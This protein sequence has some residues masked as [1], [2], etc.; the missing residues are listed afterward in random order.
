MTFAQAAIVGLLLCMFAAYATERVRIEL[1]AVTGLGLA[2][3]AGLVPVDHLFSGFS[4]PAVVTVIEILLVVSV[5]ARTRAVERVAALIVGRLRSERAVLVALCSAAA[6]VSVFMNNIGALALMFPVT[7][8]VCA[9]LGLAPGRMLMPLSFATLLGGLCSLT[10]TPANLIVN[11]WRIAETGGAFGYFDFGTVGLPV[12][13]AGI[14]WLALA[15]PFAFRRMRAD[16]ESVDLGPGTALAELDVPAGSPLVGKPLAEIERRHA[17]TIHGVVRDGAHVFARRDAIVVAAGDVLLGEAAGETIDALAAAG[18]VAQPGGAGER[19]EAVVMPDS[20]VIGSRVESLESFVE[21]GVAVVGL[22]SRRRRIEGR[23]G[24]LQIGLGDVL[25]LAGDREALRE[26]A[27]DAGLLP[28]MPRARTA[29][30]P[31]TVLSTAIFLVGVLVT[32]IGL[33]PPEVAF[34]GVVL[35]MALTGALKLSEALQ[36]VNWTIVILLACMIPLGMA[37]QETGA[38][39]VI[40]DAIVGH[41]P[42]TQPALVTA[43]VLLLAA[44]ITPFVDNVSVAA[45][46]SP[47]AAGIATRAGMPI[48]P[49]LVAV[50]IGASL[51]FLTPFG[52]HNNAV[53]MGAA[54]YRFTDFPRLGLPLLGICLVVAMAALGVVWL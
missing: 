33:A 43:T 26:T 42:T 15:A 16:P 22:A 11:D 9:R 34:G 50:A 49:L 35:A 6:F 30:Q 41:L 8:S 1:V 38:A 5:L 10:G 54:G 18:A 20:V 25:L 51:D 53:V 7:L 36:D 40:A 28:L 52:H 24:D 19:L 39:R 29:G 2:F 48:E 13:I 44:A 32:A 14:A 45:V 17:L 4:N 31:G 3:L 23:F 12:A 27:S 47:V 37:V 46:L 21:R